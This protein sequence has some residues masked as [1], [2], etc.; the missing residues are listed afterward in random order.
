MVLPVPDSDATTVPAPTPE[1][2]RMAQESFENAKKADK[3][4]DGP[5]NADATQPISLNTKKSE[6]TKALADSNVDKLAQNL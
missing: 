6:S 1:A 5:G 2:R 3:S 4:Q